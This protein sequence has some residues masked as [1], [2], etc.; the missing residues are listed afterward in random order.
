MSEK[1]NIMTTRNS[2]ESKDRLSDLTHLIIGCAYQVSNGLGTGFLE[3]IYEN[4]LTHE[5][6]KIGKDVIQQH[7]IK[8]VYDDIVMGNF[9]AD[10]LVE[11][12]VIVEIKAIQ[13]LDDIHAAQCLN[14]LRATGLPV[15]LLL[16]FGRPKLQIKR[17]LPHDRWRRQIS[18]PE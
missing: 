17:I 16:N 18:S 5:L 4:A 13:S 8:V 7:P 1:V 11:S 6:R 10:M 14:Y 9:I 12:K 2:D 3:K 15:C